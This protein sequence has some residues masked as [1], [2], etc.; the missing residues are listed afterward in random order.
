MLPPPIVKQP[1]YVWRFYLEAWEVGGQLHVLRNGRCFASAA[2][3]VAKEGGFHDLR[4]LSEDDVQFLVATCIEPGSPQENQHKDFIA[5]LDSIQK[6]SA[7]FLRNPSD[8]TEEELSWAK[9]FL[10][11]TEEQLQ[12]SVETIGEP[13]LRALRDGDRKF[14]RDRNSSL[15]FYYLS[16]QYL[17]TKAVASNV[18]RNLA[19]TEVEQFTSQVERL[20]QLIRLIRA[21]DI[22]GSLFKNRSS[23]DLVFLDNESETDFITGDQPIININAVTR[24]DTVPDRFELYY[25]VSPRRAM[26][27]TQAFPGRT[28]ER[29]PVSQ[30]VVAHHNEMMMA[31]SLEMIFATSKAALQPFVHPAS[32]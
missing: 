20:W 32:G 15:F 5:R 7:S 30:H 8:H 14:L 18:V 3:G 12:S 2:K 17:R 1:H 10:H 31:A 11:D 21:V 6:V 25:P 16:M 9:K 28:G 13:W 23:Y 19:G 27:W 4:D 29:F 22:A 24:H 26:L